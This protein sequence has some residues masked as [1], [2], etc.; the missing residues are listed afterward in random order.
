LALDLE[1]LDLALKI[2]EQRSTIRSSFRRERMISITIFVGAVVGAIRCKMKMKVR[3]TPHW[4]S[5]LAARK[6]LMQIKSAESAGPRA[7]D[8]R[9]STGRRARAI[10][11]SRHL[12]SLD[13]AGGRYS[14]RAG[15]AAW[16]IQE[17]NDSCSNLSRTR[18]V[19]WLTSKVPLTAPIPQIEIHQ[20]KSY[21]QA[22]YGFRD[23]ICDV[24]ED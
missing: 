21:E 3:R 6:P 1:L 5:A 14:F 19:I 17:L 9:N 11:P 4:T 8:Y 15:L 22:F 24:I 18:R 20:S 7:V 13:Q 16:A 12:A 2:G 23:C 10:A